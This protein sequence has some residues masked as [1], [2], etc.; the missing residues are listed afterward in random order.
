M[1]CVRIVAFAAAGFGLMPGPGLAQSVDIPLGYTINTG[2]NYGFNNPNPA[3]VLT[4]NV[5][6]NGGAAQTY[7]FDTGSSVFLAPSSVYAGGAPTVLATGVN[8]ETY[9]TSPTSAFTGDLYQISASALKFY[10]TAGATSGGISL[11][12]TGN[13]NVASYTSYSLSSG[14]ATSS[15]PFGA[16]VG[17]FG[18]SALAFTKTVAGSAIGLGSVIGQTNVANT[19]AGYMVAANGQSLA[20]LNAQLNTS[21]PGGP[22]TSAQ[23]SIQTVPQ[24]ITSC[25]PCVTVGLTPALIA[26]FQSV[27]TVAAG[28]NGIS[29]PNSNVLSMGK[30]VPLNFS[31]GFRAPFSLNV[32]L[33]TGWT[34][35]AVSSGRGAPPTLT[36]SANSNG[37]QETFNIASARGVPS[38]YALAN[39]S[40][41]ILGIGF[42]VQN[43]VLYNLAGQQV[44]YSPNFVTDANIATTQPLVID[45]NLVPLGLAGV[46]SGPG[47]LSIAAGGSA[48]LSGTN[49]YTGPTNVSGDSAYLA[50][51]GPGSIA[52]SSG[53]NVSAGGWFDVSGASTAATIK[54]LSGDVDGLVW[55]GANS[56][57]LSA[58]SGVF[59]GTIVGTGG[60]ELLSGHQTLSGINGYTGMTVVSGGTLT[61]NGTIASSYLTLVG[62]GAT[63][64]GTGTIGLLSVLDG[65]TFAPAWGMPARTMNVAG[66]LI[67][68]SGANYAVQLGA[69]SAAFANVSGNASLAGTLAISPAPGSALIRQYDLLH[70]GS[71]GG[72]SFGGITTSL[73]GFSTSLSYSA[74]DATL[75]LDAALLAQAQTSGIGANGQRIA[76]LLDASFN[77]T[78]TTSAG[79]SPLY[80]L[81]GRNLGNALTQ[82]SGEAGTG[83]QQT[84]FNAMDQFLGLLMDPGVGEQGGTRWSATSTSNFAGADDELAYAA[85]SRTRRASERDA[86]GLMAKAPLRTNYDP[87]WSVW[88]SG[89]GGSQSSDGNAAVGSNAAT[90]QVFGTA[91][92]ADY[93]LSPRTVMG[94]ALAGGGTNASVANS[95]AARSDLFQAGAFVRHKSGAAYISAGFGYGWQDITTDRTVTVSG[96]DRL[97]AEFHANAWSGR[98]EGG[99]R[100]AISSLKGF[101]ITPYAAAQFT[102][103]A[104]PA[105]AESAV[106]GAGTFALSYSGRNVTDSRSEIGV[107]TDQTFA[108]RNGLLTVN[109]RLAWA[110]DFDPDRWAAASFLALPAS[111]FTVS[112]AAQ[113]RD[114]ALTSLGADINWLNG[115]SARAGFE[116]AFADVSRSYAGKGLL[117]YAW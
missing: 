98:V 110:H 57:A 42:F 46:I 35:F 79:F 9:G 64:A 81:T 25:N 96:V 61:V 97:R 69:S 14:G 62:P 83:V 27:N 112:G 5:G 40:A 59:A 88:A 84:S 34:D 66:D 99:Y 114:A 72:T 26:Q 44:G 47:G 33:D 51:V 43:S 3:L 2:A 58:A 39:S 75:T 102:T 22:V 6:V 90:S 95:G 19:T 65:G 29:F 49:T 101:G 100:L 73:P 67:L 31:V 45:A 78:G 82:A 87:R 56:L 16:S 104:L 32:S 4:I 92:G 21:I 10:A 107:R 7:A 15:Q 60:L 108:I 8:V 117:R 30:F 80:T 1:S 109:S 55:L 53:V 23:Q 63:L 48:T 116:G 68:S 85:T 41:D 12:T 13:Y 70:S 94:F 115:W 74:T 89:F 77:T 52:P 20:A 38:P 50:L 71:L 111:G 11:G 103:I 54:S 37:T 18:A 86:Y 76:K 105:Y 106:S 36:V 91:V 24:S 93:L 17:V 113:G 28:S